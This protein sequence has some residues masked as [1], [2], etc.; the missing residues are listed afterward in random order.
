M[1]FDY[2][3]CQKDALTLELLE[4]NSSGSNLTPSH[5]LF[6]HRSVVELITSASIVK[7]L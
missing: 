4:I 5:S 3:L 6:L 7:L 1:P 2:T